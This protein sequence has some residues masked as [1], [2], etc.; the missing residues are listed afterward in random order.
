MMWWR[1][2]QDSI[3]YGNLANSSAHDYYYYGIIYSGRL[4]FEIPDSFIAVLLS[5]CLSHASSDQN[6]VKH[7]LHRRWARHWVFKD[8]EMRENSIYITLQLYPNITWH[9][10]MQ[11]LYVLLITKNWS[12]DPPLQPL[13]DCSNVS[14]MTKEAILQIVLI[15]K[16][17]TFCLQLGSSW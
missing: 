1:N 15:K 10:F 12:D 2:K 5:M 9:S 13:L 7:L 8:T 16:S 4:G 3:N 17:H 11:I 14:K 6:R